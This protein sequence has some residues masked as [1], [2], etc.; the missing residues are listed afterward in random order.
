MLAYI[1]SRSLVDD[2]KYS[3]GLI[4]FCPLL[5]CGYVVCVTCKSS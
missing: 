1:F 2:S 5:K 4:F 3:T